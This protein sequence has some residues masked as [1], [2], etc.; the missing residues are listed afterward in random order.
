MSEA[1]HVEYGESQASVQEQ[2]KLVV[3]N[4]P[5]DIV[6]ELRA[7]GFTQRGSRFVKQRP[8]LRVDPNE[9]DDSL[10]V[11]SARRVGSALHVTAEDVVGMVRLLPGLSVH[12]EPKVGWEAAFEM[13]LTVYDIDRTQSF[14]GIP[15]DELT[16]ENTASEKIVSILAINYVAGMRTVRRNGVIRELQINR[17]QGFEGYGSVDIEQTL[18]D[19]T[20]PTQAPTWIETEVDHSNPVNEAVLLA[21]RI[22]LRMLSQGGET[23][24]PRTETLLSMVHREVQRLE[25]LGI[26]D[27]PRNIARYRSLTV[28]TLPRQRHYYQRALHASRSILSSVLLGGAGTGA[29][30]LLVDYALS[31]NGLFEDYSQQ[32]IKETLND[33]KSNID[34][35]DSLDGVKC[36]REPPI[37]PF[38]GNPRAKHEPDHLLHGPLGPIAILDSKY[39][40]EGSNPANDSG[41]RSRMFTYAYLTGCN[42]M[43]FLCPELEPMSMTVQQTD[44][45]VSVVT[46]SEGFTC[47]RYRESVRKYVF[48][49]L[50]EENPVLRVF[51]ALNS[52][53]I[54]ALEGTSESDLQRASH[55]DGPFT[56][57]N[58]RTFA[59]RVVT[60]VNFSPHGPN[61]SELPNKGRFAERRIKENLTAE[62]EN[63]NPQYPKNRTTCVPIYDPN[64]EGEYGSVRLYYFL[65]NGTELTIDIS[66]PIKLL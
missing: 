4:C 45:V 60:A 7:A 50:A 5:T 66:D 35:F 38:E 47:D 6:E 54:L 18:V 26:N 41:P 49:A 1:T 57:D 62:D 61:K 9:E 16:A 64:G 44:G 48:D 40:E 29:E 53:R 33:I 39:Y 23:S 28:E 52:N 3:D 43:A 14:Y 15:L 34:R 13:L 37:R 27:S 51:E 17:R 22:L 11:L 36:S 20:G 56:I 46:P 58:E 25:A 2:Q 31:M 8:R 30:E 19:Q 55:L 59:D 12:V 32:V 63:G 21:G 10:Q 65:D 24:H 42:R